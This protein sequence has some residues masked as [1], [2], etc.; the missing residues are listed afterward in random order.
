MSSHV[1][2]NQAASQR[3]YRELIA[4]ANRVVELPGV[5]DGV[6][7]GEAYAA[8]NQVMLDHADLLLTVWDGEP[9]RGLGGTAEIVAQVQAR[10]KPV[11]WIGSRT[12]ARDLPP[13]SG[14]SGRA[15]PMVGTT[16]GGTHTA[17]QHRI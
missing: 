13:R 14:W 12:A 15:G 11:V 2:S 1:I 4:R 5:R 3:E 17:F 16:R 7:D 10:G 8:A 9:A 6:G